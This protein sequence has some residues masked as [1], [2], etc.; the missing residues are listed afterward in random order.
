MINS[1]IAGFLRGQ[2]FVVNPGAENNVEDLVAYADAAGTRPVDG[3]GGSPN[4]TVTRTTTNALD[5][6][7]SY[8]I[9]KDAANRQGQGASITFSVPAYLVNQPE[10]INISFKYKVAS[11]TFAFGGDGTDGDL[12]V[13]IYDVTNSALIEP[14]DFKLL[15]DGKVSTSFQTAYGASSYRLILHV[16]STSTQAWTLEVDKLVVGPVGGSIKPNVV[17]AK[18]LNA[19]ASYTVSTTQPFQYNTKVYDTAGLVTTGSSWKVTA[20]VSGIY[21]CSIMQYMGSATT[22]HLYVNGT[23]VNAISDLT[24]GYTTSTFSQYLKAGEY[25]DIRTGSSTTQPNDVNT[26]FTVKLIES[27]QESGGSRV[28]STKAQRASSNQTISTTA[29]TKIQFNS[30]ALADQGYDKNGAFD[31]GNN[32]IVA[33]ESG[34]YQVKASILTSGVTSGTTVTLTIYKNGSAYFAKAVDSAGTAQSVVD[35]FDEIPL[36]AGD[37]IELYIASPDGSYDIAASGGSFLIVTKVGAS[38][39]VLDSQSKIYL[40]YVDNSGTGITANTTNIPFITKVVDSHGAWN[41]SQFTAPRSGWYDF[42]GAIQ[43]VSASGS[44]TYSYINGT[45]DASLMVSGVGAPIKPMAGGAYLKAGDVLS[46]RT[47]ATETLTSGATF[48]HIEIRSQ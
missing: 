44:I 28:I 47:D 39:G 6:V 45:I 1:D 41:G 2:N 33:Q 38:G 5:G 3:T 29:A 23:I 42:T 24:T 12:I 14:V 19:G 17:A 8:L 46:F 43:T 35:I 4:I 48:H 7:A 22:I 37:Y 32:R 10:V 36:N 27:S 34:L 9:T 31:A 15:G 16:S 11:G 13:Y 40:K 21:E 18:Y 30:V 26:S 20:P 25:L